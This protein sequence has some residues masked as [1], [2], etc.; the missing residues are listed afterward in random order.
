MKKHKNIVYQS[1]VIV[2]N[3]DGVLLKTTELTTVR[4]V[5]KDKFMQVYLDDFASLMKINSGAE[6]KVVL[7]IGNEMGFNTN[8]IVLV[9]AIKE[10]ISKDTDINIRTINNTITSLTEKGI[11]LT[12][13]RSIYTLNPKLFFK[14]SLEERNSCVKRIIEY[15]INSEENEKPA[16]E[17]DGSQA[18]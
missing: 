3:E 9:K 2:T 15:Q 5:T 6:Y 14:G 18:G 8:E 13:S 10:R 1:E 11:L 12:I 4:K 17:F 7:W 16:E